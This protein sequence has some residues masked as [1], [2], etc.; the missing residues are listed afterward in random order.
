MQRPV[1]NVDVGTEALF[2][3]LI[4]FADDKSQRFRRDGFPHSPNLI[5]TF[6]RAGLVVF[7]QILH[8]A[9]SLGVPGFLV[10][11]I[12]ASTWSA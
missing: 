5:D 8:R 10:P 4:K 6:L 1:Q 2:K 12:L 9:V 7:Q 3:F 11:G